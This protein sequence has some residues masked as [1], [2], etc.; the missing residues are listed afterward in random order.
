MGA[1]KLELQGPRR[2]LSLFQHHDGV[3][4][5]ARTDVV[6]DY[7]KRIHAA[8]GETQTWMVQHLVT[9]ESKAMSKALQVGPCW[10]SDAPRGLSENLCESQ[11]N[12]R[13][14]HEVI[15]YNPLDTEQSCGSVVVPGWTKAHATLP[16][17]LPGPAPGSKTAIQFDPS[18]GLMTHPIREEWMV[19]Q[20]NQGGAYLFFPGT[21]TSY[22]ELNLDIQD[23]G[24]VVSA[25]DWKRTVVERKTPDGSG[26]AGSTV[27]D[28]IYETNLRNA[29]EEWFARFTA[30][31]LRNEGVFHTDLNG[32][33]FDTH[34]FRSDMPIQSQVFPMPTHASIE[35]AKRRFTIL[36][37]HAQGTASLEEGSI[38]VWLDRRLNQDDNRG[39]GQP[40]LDNVPTRTRL[41]IV[42]ETGGYDVKSPEFEI[43]PF[44]KQQWKEL[45]HPLEMFGRVSSSPKK[46][47]SSSRMSLL[48]LDNSH[49]EK[50]RKRKARQKKHAT[51][52]AGVWDHKIPAVFLVYN[53]PDYL[54]KAI[55]SLRLSDYPR[56]EVPIIISHD[57][58]VKEMMAYVESIKSEFHVIQLF[59]P[60]ACSEHP[61]TFPGDDPKLNQDY[62][63]DTYGN[64]REAK[65]CCL[66]HH[67]TWMIN[68]VF[69]LKETK[70]AD[71]FLF[72]EE[73]YIVAPT[74]YETVQNGFNY[75]D[76]SDRQ[77]D[78]FG[79]TLDPT[80]GYGKVV[81][82]AA[83]GKWI[84]KQFVTGP[85]AIRRDMFAKIKANA[86]DYCT[87]D[88]Y[89][90]D[91]SV[92]HLMVKRALPYKVL[93]PSKLQAAHIG[94]E[95]GLHENSVGLAKIRA[96][97][98]HVKNL[99]P[100]HGKPD[101]PFTRYMSMRPANKRGFGGW[102]HPADHEHCLKL[103]GIK[104]SRW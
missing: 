75:I 72:L 77:N 16:C 83:A 25:K 18:T 81:P 23:G 42:I 65:I 91:W 48:Q 82:R 79:V 57:G 31:G 9:V 7:A 90:W 49:I 76:E 17:E 64:K 24:Y 33:N 86:R 62:K 45:N 20:V 21:L 92:V 3:T 51:E 8:I 28:F 97:K 4:G 88:D 47:K 63:G 53:R 38:D 22:N 30:E 73:D 50:V 19:W 13:E 58:H 36:S 32:Y 40:V 34:H 78:F 74:V 26:G 101:A 52:Q 35:D 54:K 89:N 37:E 93:V 46:L 1:T 14:E 29:N 27:I 87:F 12:K 85:M 41:R 94:M 103:F 96:M 69:G 39:L 60:H 44:C 99:G 98:F 2:A 67:F 61:S 104:K 95:G 59:H 100:F 102:G 84:E 70:D 15:L 68:E 10:H 71:A 11:S 5:T 66:K 56:D 55:D 43:T 80:E 6:E